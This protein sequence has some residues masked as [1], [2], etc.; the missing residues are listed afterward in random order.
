MF[1]VDYCSSGINAGE[2]CVVCRILQ[3]NRLPFV[4]AR[5]LTIR[6]SVVAAVIANC[7]EDSLENVVEFVSHKDVVRVCRTGKM[8]AGRNVLEAVRRNLTNSNG[9]VT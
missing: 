3:L 9:V 5:G 2:I 4:G 8:S 7:P 1:V 6:C